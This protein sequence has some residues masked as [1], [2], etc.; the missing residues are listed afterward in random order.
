MTYFL[1]LG[2]PNILSP[3][4][5]YENHSVDAPKYHK[6][7]EDNG[8]SLQ[9]YRSEYDKTQKYVFEQSKDNSHYLK[10]GK[11]ATEEYNFTFQNDNLIHLTVDGE[12]IFEIDSDL[13]ALTL[14]EK[15][16]LYYS[17]DDIIIENN[18]ISLKE[19]KI[20]LLHDG[21]HFHCFKGRKNL[22]IQ[23][24]GNLYYNTERALYSF[25]STFNQK[26]NNVLEE[27]I[28]HTT[29]ETSI[30]EPQS[31]PISPTL[32]KHPRPSE[33]KSTFNR[34]II[35]NEAF[36]V[37]R[38]KNSHKFNINSGSRDIVAY[39]KSNSVRNSLNKR[40]SLLS[41]EENIEPTRKSYQQPLEGF[42]TAQ[43]FV[44]KR[45]ILMNETQQVICLSQSVV[46][47]IP[48]S[49]VLYYRQRNILIVNREG[50]TVGVIS[51]V[52]HLTAEI[53]GN[54]FIMKD[55]SSNQFSAGRLF[56]E[57]QNAFFVQKTS[58]IF[59]IGSLILSTTKPSNF[60]A[61]SIILL[62]KKEYCL[63]KIV[64]NNSQILMYRD[65]T[66]HIIKHHSLINYYP[67][68]KQF[69]VINYDGRVTYYQG[70][71]TPLNLLSGIGC[72]YVGGTTALY[73][74][75]RY[76]HNEINDYILKSLLCSND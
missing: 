40:D 44:N 70:L 28:L 10:I 59:Q 55:S 29:E 57:N 9:E 36:S 15:T 2:A 64:V 24:K 12:V 56:V 19:I 66:L 49:L 1:S 16:T 48:T 60:V 65:T 26:L 69:T 14:D 30:S 41:F 33:M 71:S 32:M 76:L 31:V 8:Y 18:R 62:Y 61:H 4:E 37:D 72:L 7:P 54:L 47:D 67:N 52:L 27:F 73:S 13:H 45:I 68:I 3:E 50:Q 6:T 5:L 39:D 63:Q 23:I 74:T 58:T 11:E 17:N 22:P 21:F 46:Y 34:Q 35:T 20:L 38:N 53:N 25:D 51:G 42:P 43:I 75:T